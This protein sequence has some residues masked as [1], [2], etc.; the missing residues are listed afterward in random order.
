M[1]VTVAVGVAVSMLVA[2]GVALSRAASEARGPAVTNGTNES[3]AAYNATREVFGG[4]LTAA[5]PGVVWFGVAAV[6]L[7]SLGI[8]VSVA[9]GGR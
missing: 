9:G 7:V 6:V 2:G 8:L 4:F 5:G 1:R 3:A